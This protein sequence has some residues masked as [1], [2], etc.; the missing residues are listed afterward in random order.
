MAQA[1]MTQAQM[2][3]AQMAQAQMAL[4]QMAQAQMAQA[5]MAQAQMAQAQ[6][7]Q[8]QM[9]QAQMAQAQM[10]QARIDF[11][12]QMAQARMAQAQMAQIAPMD[13]TP[14]VEELQRPTFEFEKELNLAGEPPHAQLAKRGHTAGAIAPPSSSYGDEG[15]NMHMSES[16]L[17]DHRLSIDFSIG[18]S[19]DALL[20]GAAEGGEGAEV[21]EVGEVGEDENWFVQMFS[22]DGQ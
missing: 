1:Q 16:T 3:Q 4:A 6:M 2:A 7:A 18:P 8:A 22:F 21:G 19:A 12:S 17:D 5:Q 20:A 13:Q 9:A 15:E 10:A 11:Q 14:T